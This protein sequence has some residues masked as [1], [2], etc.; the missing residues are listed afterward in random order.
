MSTFSDIIID[1]LPFYAVL[2]VNS[3]NIWDY[4]GLRSRVLTFFLSDALN[5]LELCIAYLI[6]LNYSFGKNYCLVIARTI[7]LSLFSIEKQH[8]ANSQLRPIKKKKEKKN[9]RKASSGT[10]V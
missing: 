5:I 2:V 8:L 7:L 4:F 6:S 9:Y 3:V 1:R 10:N